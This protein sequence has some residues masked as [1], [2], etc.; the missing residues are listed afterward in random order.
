M[1][2]AKKLKQEGNGE[3][4]PDIEPI[5]A[6]AARNNR[7]NSVLFFY[8]SVGDRVAHF[9][10]IF[11]SRGQ[12]WYP[13]SG[14]TDSTGSIDLLDLPWIDNKQ[15]FLGQ[16]L[17]VSQPEIDGL[18]EIQIN[19]EFVDDSSPSAEEAQSLAIAKCITRM[20]NHSLPF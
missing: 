8:D 20:K 3:A 17:S 6:E 11:G 5:E 12:I 18:W 1:E 16:S 10:R 13:K 9:E 19:G 2:Y 15:I 14:A 7:V 4:I